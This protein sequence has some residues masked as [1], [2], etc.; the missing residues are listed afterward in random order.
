MKE[1]GRVL[2]IAAHPDDAE[3]SV[4]GTIARLREGGVDVAVANFTTSEY[5]PAMLENRRRAA[6]Q[7][8]EILGHRLIWIEDGRHNQVEDIA[9]YRLVGLIDDIVKRERPDAVIGPWSEDSHV[10][11]ARLARATTASSR[12]WDADLYAYC[13]AEFRAA[14][15][16]R[17]SPNF[18]VDISPFVERKRAAIQT[19]NYDGGGFRRLRDDQLA[20]LWSCQ[21][22]LHGWEYAE[23]LILLRARRTSERDVFG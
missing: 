1:Q 16:Q 8:A 21:G 9:E 17:F 10:D 18:F 15:F 6:A 19:F 7:A 3:I 4:G 13:P 20:R 2:V 11:H 5:S 22:A 12:C 23:G 14:S